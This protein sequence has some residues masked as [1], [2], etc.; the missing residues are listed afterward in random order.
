MRGAFPCPASLFE[1]TGDANEHENEIGVAKPRRPGAG[2]GDR[3]G[4]GGRPSA[5]DNATSNRCAGGDRT[6]RGFAIVLKS[7]DPGS[8]TVFPNRS[9]LPA[10]LNPAALSGSGFS[11]YQG[12]PLDVPPGQAVP[13]AAGTP[14]AIALLASGPITLHSVTIASVPEPGGLTLAALGAAVAGGALSRRRP[15]P[16]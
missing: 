12:P 7:A 11:I 16:A 1:R 3:I 14:A 10:T 15:C 9:S 5:S 13:L 2:G 6:G 4:D 8:V